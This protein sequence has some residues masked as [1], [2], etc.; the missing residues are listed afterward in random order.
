MRGRFITLEGGE[1]S[2]KSTQTGRLVE[3]LKARVQFGQALST[4]QALQHKSAEMLIALEQGRSAAI[5]AATALSEADP[6]V[7]AGRMGLGTP[8]RRRLRLGHPGG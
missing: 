4:F 6:L 1:G 3:H 8:G 2:G 7:R 5:L